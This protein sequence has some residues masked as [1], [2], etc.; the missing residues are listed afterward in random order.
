MSRTLCKAKFISFE[1][2]EGSGKS[3]QITLLEK[4]L[5][6]K[7]LSVIRTREPGGT[8][9]AEMLRSVLKEN[10]DAQWDAVSQTL[11]LYAARRDL[12]E[13]V[14]KPALRK[15]VWVLSDRFADSTYVY[16]GYTQDV[17]VD[18]IDT[19]HKY[20]LDNLYPDL[21]FYMDLTPEQGFRRV[22]GRNQETVAYHHDIFE[23]QDM[24]FHKRVQE[25]FQ[26]LVTANP[27]RM[28]T[29]PAQ[30]SVDQVH[31]HIMT[32]LNE[33]FDLRL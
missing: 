18:F 15:N 28:V 24:Q 9:G 25:G 21:T 16:Q 2:G 7:G 6:K 30:F 27:D 22:E 17:S 11:I 20:A 3:T 26:D 19:L 23:A 32:V 29:I 14:I 5:E 12:V 8:I 10:E 4:E 13:K 1:G 33:K 31:H